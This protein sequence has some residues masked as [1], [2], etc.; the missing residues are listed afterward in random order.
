MMQIF[1]FFVFVFCFFLYCSALNLSTLFQ[2]TLPT[3]FRFIVKAILSTSAVFIEMC[4]GMSLKRLYFFLT[5][6]ISHS[7]SLTLTLLFSLLSLVRVL[8]S[9]YVSLKKT[10]KTKK[11]HMSKRSRFV[12]LFSIATKSLHCNVI[13]ARCKYCGI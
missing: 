8:L 12:E 7:V 13:G 5:F 11:K 4:W 6:Y 9:F 2:Q 10:K 1:Y 3:T